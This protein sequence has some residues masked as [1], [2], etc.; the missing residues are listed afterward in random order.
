MTALRLRA[1]LFCAVLGLGAGAAAQQPAKDAAPGPN[2]AC[3]M[4]HGDAGAKAA[5]GKSVAVDAKRFAASVHGSMSLPCVACHTDPAVGQMPHGAVKPA[6]CD[7][8]HDKAVKEYA[9][10]VHGK[11]RSGGNHVAATCASCHGAHDIQ[12]SSEPTSRTNHANLEATCGACHGNEAIIKQA[13]L[14]GGNVAGMFHDS[15]HGQ[16][17]ANKTAA[18][19]AVPTCTG[20][21]GAHDI[22]AKSD[23][24]SRVSRARS[25]AM[26]ARATRA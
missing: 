20:C 16:A 22:R 13:N 15:V 2:D 14:P 8:C 26:C 3:L 18:K 11:A 17:M 25:P 19:D 9:A 12:K 6:Q 5:S 4:C 23:P 1:L 24:E 7:S 21:H 10:T